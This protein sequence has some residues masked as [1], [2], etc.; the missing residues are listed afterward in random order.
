MKCNQSRPGFELVSP[1]S[2]PTAITITPRAESVSYFPEVA[3]I[4]FCE[5][6][7]MREFLAD[8][9]YELCVGIVTSARSVT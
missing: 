1:C 5:R 8:G 6:T 2:F 4:G 7:V 3:D 9:V